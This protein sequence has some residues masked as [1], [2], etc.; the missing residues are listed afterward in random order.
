VKLLEEARKNA[1]T[2]RERTNI[3]I[4]LAQAIRS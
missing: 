4:A 3:E 1:A 2:D